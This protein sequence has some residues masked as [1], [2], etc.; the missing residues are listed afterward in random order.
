M[1]QTETT[2]TYLVDVTFRVT[3]K[4][5]EEA[6]ILASTAAQKGEASKAV[7]AHVQVEHVAEPALQ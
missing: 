4:D 1:S 6:W 3:A 2:K 7:N 5:Q